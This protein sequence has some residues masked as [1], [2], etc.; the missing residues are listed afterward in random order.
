MANHDNLET[1]DSP[2]SSITATLRL[3]LITVLNRLSRIPTAQC[4]FESLTFKAYAIHATYRIVLR[5]STIHNRS[6]LPVRLI[7]VFLFQKKIVEKMFGWQHQASYSLSL[8]IHISLTLKRKFLSSFQ[9][10]F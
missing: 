9:S 2:A 3:C 1:P 8:P 4:V 7:L 6:D 10:F 5:F